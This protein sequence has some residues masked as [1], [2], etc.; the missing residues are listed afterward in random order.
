MTQ[1]DEE[2]KL[3][4]KIVI[5]FDICSSTAILEDLKQTD[6]LAA[7]RNLLIDMKNRLKY[8]ATGLPIEVYKFIGDGWILLL[9]PDAVSPEQFH[10]VLKNISMW[11]FLMFGEY[12]RPLLQR[13]PDP[14][15]LTFGMDMGD[16][17]RIE[18][19]EQKEYIGRAINVASRLQ[20]AIK[21][22]KGNPSGKVLCSKPLFNFVWKNNT[23]ELEGVKKEIVSLRNIANGQNYE[24]VQFV[25]PEMLLPEPEWDN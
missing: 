11:F 22:L 9:S 12:V 3:E 4:R 10:H 2:V 16:L 20:G 1:I 24:C 15:G 5:V 7:W 18:M 25:L 14:I 17:I 21:S 23:V 19:N 8:E 6:N 13:E